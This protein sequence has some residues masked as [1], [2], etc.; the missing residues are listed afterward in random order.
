MARTGSTKTVRA[1]QMGRV[2][3]RWECSGLSLTEFARREGLVPSTLAWW[4]HVFRKAD[5]AGGGSGDAV[6]SFAEVRLTAAP[7]RIAPMG[8][9]V[10]LR[11]GHLVRVPAGFDPAVLREVVA[12]L[13][14]FAPC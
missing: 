14:G 6:A 11:S 9:E 4:R 1:Q 12:V 13:D 3:Q 7:Q 10:V 5:Q 8:I 2:L